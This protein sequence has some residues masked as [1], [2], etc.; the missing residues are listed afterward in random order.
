MS[1]SI[2][3]LPHRREQQI[4]MAKNWY[5][6]LHRAG[7]AWGIP[8]TVAS[9]LAGLYQDAGDMLE[10]ALS[11]ARTAVITARC[12]ELFHKLTAKMRDIKKRYFHTPPLDEAN[13]AELGLKEPDTVATPIPPPTAQAEA[14][15]TFPGIH[16]VELKNIR[17]V[18]G[19][20]PDGRSDYD[21]RVFWGL[22]GPASG[23]DKFRVT[24]APKSGNDLP[25]SQFTRRRKEL[26]DRRSK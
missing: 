18:A 6:V 1:Q 11:N 4:A 19:A 20:A 10:D 7:T 8:P 3:W 14:D 2:D 16:L 5:T 13:Y 9:D 12:N 17:P 23:T 15:L 22:T 21:V 26:F 24:D 25:H